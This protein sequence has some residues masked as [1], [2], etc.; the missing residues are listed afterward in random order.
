MVTGVL[1]MEWRDQVRLAGKL[2]VEAV[3]ELLIVLRKDADR[4][5]ALE[6]GD[7][8][9]CPSVERQALRAAKFLYRQL[10]VVADNKAVPRIEERGRDI[11]T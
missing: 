9:E 1:R 8:R 11:A 6:G 2:E 3:L 5:A 4:E 7:T 10:P